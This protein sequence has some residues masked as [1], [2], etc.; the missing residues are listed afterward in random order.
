[1]SRELQCTP[2]TLF[3]LLVL[4]A[5][6]CGASARAEEDHHDEH[7]HAGFTVEDFARFG[8]TLATAGPADVDAGV[9]LPGEIRPNAD[10]LAHVAARFPGI[11]RAVRA[12]VGD[13]VRAGD[14]LAVVESE[15]L[16]TYEVRAAFDGTVIDRHVAPGEAVTRERPLFV[17]ADLSTVWVDVSVYQPALAAVRVG[18]PVTFTSD[19]GALAA[20]GSVSYVSPVVDQAT[21]TARARVVLPNDDGRWRPGTFVT[22]TVLEPTPVAVAVPRRALQRHEGRE[23]VFVVD[24]ERFVARPVVVGRTGRTVAEITSGVEAGERVAD[25]RSFLVKAELGKGVGGHDH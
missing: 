23:V 15:S 14:V 19:G 2:R 24:G 9:E 11:A 18:Q 6:L 12:R 21:R 5:L 22:A 20:T 1:M 17:V 10:R 13:A 25:D 16:A 3:A 4:G 8:V 7:G